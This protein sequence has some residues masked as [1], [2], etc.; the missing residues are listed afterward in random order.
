MERGPEVHRGL[1]QRAGHPEQDHAQERG[2]ALLDRREPRHLPRPAGGTLRQGR[3]HPAHRAPELQH[4][5]Q[6]GR[7][8][9]RRRA[10]GE[11]W[12]RDRE[13]KGH[14][15]RQGGSLHVRERSGAVH[16]LHRDQDHEPPVLHRHRARPLWP[17]HLPL[18]RPGLPARR[19]RVVGPPDPTRALLRP[20]VHVRPLVRRVGRRVLLRPAGR[21]GGPLA[22]RAGAR[23]HQQEHLSGRPHPVHA[24]RQRA[25]AAGHDD[26]RP[27]DHLLR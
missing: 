20:C 13:Q 27:G 8:R 22:Q 26:R 21:R 14:L 25:H 3:Q 7:V 18:A 4:E 1:R 16:G 2:D 15:R 17:E 10:E 24:R 9:V 12:Q 5:R 11:G 6:R 19:R 23:L